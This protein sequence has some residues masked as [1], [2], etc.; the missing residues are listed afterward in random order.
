MQLKVRGSH[1]TCKLA[2]KYLDICEQVE[3]VE[4]N[5]NGL[6]PPPSV[7][8]SELSVSVKENLDRKKK[9]MADRSNHRRCS[10]RKL[11]LKV[12]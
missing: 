4:R 8:S 9:K 3:V 5:K 7:L 1:F 12:A 10:I 2:N 11:F 6:L